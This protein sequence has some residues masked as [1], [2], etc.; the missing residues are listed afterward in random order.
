MREPIIIGP[1]FQQLHFCCSNILQHLGSVS[2]SPLL[3]CSSL[4]AFFA[5]WGLF[6]SFP[7]RILAEVVLLKGWHWASSIIMDKEVPGPYICH[8]WFWL[9]CSKNLVLWRSSLFDFVKVIFSL[10]FKQIF[11]PNFYKAC[12]YTLQPGRNREG[13]LRM[14]L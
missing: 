9:F 2:L 10:Q 14:C 4:V 6:L 1:P 7:P 8:P 11:V 13:C 12:W 5:F 3:V